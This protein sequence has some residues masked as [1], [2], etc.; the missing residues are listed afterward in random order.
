MQSR[1]GVLL[2]N[3]GTPDSPKRGDVARYLTQFLLDPRVIDIPAW[4]RQLLVRAAIVPF[5]SRTSGR[6]YQ[7]IWTDKGSPLLVH[8]LAMRDALQK[9]LGEAYVVKLGMRYQN[10]PLAD[11]LE[12]LRQAKVERIVVLPLFPQYASASTGSAHQ[13]VMDLVSRDPIVP[14][15]N[16]I[17]SYP[18][19]PQ[20]IAAFA[21]RAREHRLGDFDHFLFSFHGLPERQIR[22]CDESNRCLTSS[23]CC[24]T[25]NAD[26][27]YCYRAQCTATAHAIST[28][29]S[30]PRESW[31]MS[32]QSRLGKDPWIQPFTPD[33]LKALAGKGMKRVLVFCPSFVCDCLETTYEIGIEAQHDFAKWGGEKVQLVAGLGDHP[34]WIEALATLACR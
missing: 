12:E 24:A 25:R 19:E 13:L 7:E 23:D 2:V 31:S 18:T 5:R 16:F 4:K 17:N 27:A 21:E 15:I 32:F 30:L 22:A 28:A 3:L 29:L 33:V 20:M 11:A 6:T 1:T 26:N 14:A 10:P 34:L 8:S 9:R